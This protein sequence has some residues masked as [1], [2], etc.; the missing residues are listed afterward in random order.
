VGAQWQADGGGGGGGKREFGLAE[1]AVARYSLSV[2]CCEPNMSNDSADRRRW[3]GDNNK[4][5]AA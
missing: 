4:K 3:L 5:R 1:P 2:A